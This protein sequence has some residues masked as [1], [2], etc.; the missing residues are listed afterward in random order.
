MY[1]ATGTRWTVHAVRTT[2]TE[3]IRIVSILQRRRTITWSYSD[4]DKVNTEAWFT[5]AT[6]REAE[7]ETEVPNF[8]QTL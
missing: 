4:K 6:E 1:I 8:I 5:L 3:Q 2:P 7:T